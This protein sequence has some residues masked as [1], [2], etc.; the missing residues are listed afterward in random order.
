LVLALLLTFLL[1]RWV[2]N[3]VTEPLE[4]LRDA[5]EE[6]SLGNLHKAVPLT[7]SAELLSLGE[8][9]DRMRTSLCTLLDTRRQDPIRAQLAEW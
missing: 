7:G 5:A 3:S 6:M 1:V 4:R 2:R 8:S 9:L